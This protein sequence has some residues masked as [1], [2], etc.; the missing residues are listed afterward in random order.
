MSCFMCLMLFV[1][2][3]FIY[4]NDWGSVINVATP[5]SFPFSP[6]FCSP[7]IPNIHTPTYI[8]VPMRIRVHRR[9]LSQEIILV[10]ESWGHILNPSFPCLPPTSY[11]RVHYMVLDPLEVGVAPAIFPCIFELIWKKYLNN[12][13]SLKTVLFTKLCLC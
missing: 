3:P 10:S 1:T 8:M 5:S 4:I 12:Y 9:I 13:R 7:I 2:C 11:K 6:P